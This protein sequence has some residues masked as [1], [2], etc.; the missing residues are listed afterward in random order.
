[1]SA[2]EHKWHVAYP[3]AKIDVHALIPARQSPLRSTKALEWG[4]DSEHAGPGSPVKFIGT[5]M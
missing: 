4:S 5:L 3:L 1:M 2:H